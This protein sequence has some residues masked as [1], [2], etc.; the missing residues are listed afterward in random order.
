MQILTYFLPIIVFLLDIIVMIICLRK[1]SSQI[2]F[3]YF[4]RNIWI[5]IV[6][7][8]SFIGQIM[9]FA[10]EQNENN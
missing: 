10:M 4:N 3:N 6:I 8:G 2:Y 5:F 7:F 9:Y 1:I